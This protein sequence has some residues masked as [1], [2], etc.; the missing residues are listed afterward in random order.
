MVCKWKKAT[1]HN[2][3]IWVD[4]VSCSS[5]HEPRFLAIV[6][7]QTSVD[8]TLLQFWMM[9]T[10][11]SCCLVPIIKNSV[12]SLM[13]FRIPKHRIPEITQAKFSQ[14]PGSTGK[15]LPDSGIRI[16]LHMW[17][18]FY[19]SNAAVYFSLRRNV[20]DWPRYFV[21]FTWVNE[22]HLRSV[23]HRTVQRNEPVDG[24]F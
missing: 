21:Q 6:T 23:S 13:G 15:N 4:I 12:P 20:F 16:P 17:R 8:R 5:N 24:E 7:G 1:P 2:L 14:I 3:L 19:S 22:E 11:A 10:F 9:I 18:M